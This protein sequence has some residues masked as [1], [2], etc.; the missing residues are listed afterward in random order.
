MTLQTEHNFVKMGTQCI[1]HFSLGN[2]EAIFWTSYPL[3]LVLLGGRGRS[4]C[5]IKCR[6]EL[7]RPI[8]NSR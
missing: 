4:G 2:E 5:Q 6:M 8:G 7:K 1:E 3:H